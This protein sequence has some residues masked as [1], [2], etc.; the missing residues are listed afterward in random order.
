[1]L[2][3]PL[4]YGLYGQKP[5]MGENLLYFYKILY[6]QTTI[7]PTKINEVKTVLRYRYELMRPRIGI[8]ILPKYLLDVLVVKSVSRQFHFNAKKYLR[9]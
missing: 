6:I 4:D 7:N 8:V 2:L 9:L 5:F 3:P 1:M